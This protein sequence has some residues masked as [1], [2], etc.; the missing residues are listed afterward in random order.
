[1]T[2]PTFSEGPAVPLM[3]EG[4]VDENT[5][6]QLGDELLSATSIISIREKGNPT[7]HAADG[8]LTVNQALTRLLSGYVRAIQVRYA[9]AGH[10]WTDTILSMP[11]G[12]RIVRCRHDS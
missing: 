7:S 3:I 2:Q 5:L 1:M 10:E 11:D 6:R 8:E 4:L 9:F 12:Y